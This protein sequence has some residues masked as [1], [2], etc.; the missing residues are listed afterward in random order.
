MTFHIPPSENNLRN[1]KS[2]KLFSHLVNESLSKIR[3]MS[4]TSRVGRVRNKE[5]WKTSPA[6]EGGHQRKNYIVF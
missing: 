6:P 3:C 1:S 5:D 4:T 2:I